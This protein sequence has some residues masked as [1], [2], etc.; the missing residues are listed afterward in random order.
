MR[1]NY[2]LNSIGCFSI[3]ALVFFFGENEIIAKENSSK[4]VENSVSVSV[5]T[6]ENSISSSGKIISGDADSRVE[7]QN[8]TNGEEKKT[9]IEAQA[10]V[11][12]E[13][14][15]ASVEVNGEKKS[16][17]AEDENGC[18]VE[19]TSEGN[20]EKNE[21]KNGSIIESVYEFA[22]KLTEKIREWF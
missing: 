6:G 2:I 3:F 5:N 12:G 13:K 22:S 16:C 21:N 4:N 8:Y 1:R 10:K 7:A 11:Q 19:I 9:K 15:T 20:L 14:S 18:E 17:V